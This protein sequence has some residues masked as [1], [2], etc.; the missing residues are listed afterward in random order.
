[1]GRSNFPVFAG[2]LGDNTPTDPKKIAAKR[3]PLK[4]FI[5]QEVRY[6]NELKHE[7][8]LLYYGVRKSED[9]ENHYDILMQRLDSDLTNYIDYM[10]NKGKMNDKLMDDIFLQ[11]TSGLGY[12][13]EQGLIHRDIKPENVLVQLRNGQSPV[14]ILADFGFIHR[15]PMSI[16]G[17]PGF[18]AP[19]ILVE[20][21]EDT[22]ITAKID[23]YALG[24]TIQQVLEN[25]SAYKKGKYVK[26]WT[27][28]S[29]RC[30]LQDPFQRPTCEKI[31]EEHNDL[32]E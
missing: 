5:W 13:H 26:F 19:E 32:T 3:V 17:T 9:M 8:I 1:L 7:N 10:L 25:S 21:A 6:M 18:F 15:V 2:E 11:I 30:L 27:D 31:L 24:A 22:F 28:I 12:L 16:K 23:I 4:R 14:F 29:R 20:N